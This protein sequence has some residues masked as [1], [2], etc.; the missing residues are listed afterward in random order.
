M[1]TLA[2]LV[3]C[4]ALAAC[5]GLAQ[6]QPADAI[7]VN[8]KVLVGDERFSVRQALAVRDGRVLATGRTAE[9]RRLAGP[10]TQVVDLRGRTVVPG[11]IDSHMHAIRA[12]LSFSTE[13][14]WIGA[15][16]LEE[17]LGRIREGA[18]R[19][20][21]GGWLIVAGGWTEHQFREKRRPTQAELEAAAPGHPVYVQWFYGWAMMTRPALAALKIQTEADLPTGGK[22]ELGPGQIPTRDQALRMYTAGSAWFDHSEGRRGSLEKGKV[23]YAAGPFEKL[24]A[25]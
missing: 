21:P 13:V 17:A 9:I 15:A 7:L 10:G 4:S 16:S 2:S 25:K 18:K 6:A 11:L 1:R 12:A 23:V 5:A 19:A 8:G 14:N 24:E 20:A 22:L 3:V